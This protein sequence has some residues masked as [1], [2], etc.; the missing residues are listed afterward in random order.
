M[1]KTILAISILWLFTLASCVKAGDPISQ[2]FSTKGDYN[3]LRIEDAFDVIVS[4]TVDQIVI[5]AGENVMPYVIVK[6]NGKTLNIYLKG[7]HSNRNSEMKVILPY[8]ASVTKVDLSGAS[9][10]HTDFGLAGTKV[11][12]DLSGASGFYGNIVADEIDIELSGS[13]DFKGNVTATELELNFSGSSDATIEGQVSELD[14]DLSGASTIAKTVNGNQY[15]LSCQTCEG[16][17]S[18]SS[19]AYIHCDGSIS[20]DLSGSSDLYYTGR[21]STRGCSTSGSSNVIHDSL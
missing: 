3:E 17:M 19:D 2:T 6:E 5:T 16:D 21:A 12:L 8:N 15:A 1:K 7:W 11:E 10:F 18:G 4:D 20:V 13:A 9:D 14:I